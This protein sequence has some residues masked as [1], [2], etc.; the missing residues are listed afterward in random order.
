MTETYPPF[1]SN[2]YPEYLASRG[3]EDVDNLLPHEIVTRKSLLKIWYVIDGFL[4]E[5]MATIWQTEEAFMNDK[6]IH[7][8]YHELRDPAKGNHYYL[9]E[10][11]TSMNQLRDEVMSPMFFMNFLHG[12][13]RNEL[14]SMKIF[15]NKLN[16]PSSLR[17]L[18][19]HNGRPSLN[20][21]E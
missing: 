20:S 16:L 19:R 21:P 5:F 3:L 9:K 4:K 2:R 13:T 14:V 6:Q 1:V 12:L 18:P 7:R 11:L 8:F 15:Q 10:V 17:N